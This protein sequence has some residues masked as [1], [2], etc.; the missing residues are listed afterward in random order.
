[1]GCLSHH[2]TCHYRLLRVKVSVLLKEFLLEI[3]RL[4]R[5]SWGIKLDNVGI[6]YQAY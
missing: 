2:A 6:A 1:M 3:I 5:H 4:S